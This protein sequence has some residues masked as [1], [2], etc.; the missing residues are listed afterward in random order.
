MKYA[1]RFSREAAADID[2]LYHSDRKLFARILNKINSLEGNPEEGKQLVGN[3]KGEYFLRVGNYRIVYELD[4]AKH[5]TYILT[6]K[7]R[8]H[9]Y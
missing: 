5:T 3:H 9:V 6:I 2:T 7:H 1:I 4:Q 8:K